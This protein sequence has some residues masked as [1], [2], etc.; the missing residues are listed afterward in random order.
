MAESLIVG[1]VTGS[2]TLYLYVVSFG[3]VFFIF[4]VNAR[5]EI[6]SCV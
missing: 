3:N 4:Y 5:C 2:E 6:A 1:L